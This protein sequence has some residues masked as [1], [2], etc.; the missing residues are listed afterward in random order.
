MNSTAVLERQNEILRR[1]IETMIIK[2]NRDG[3]SRQENGFYHTMVKEWHQNQ[4]EI[5]QMRD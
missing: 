3:L 4:Y 5:N 1:N 2:N